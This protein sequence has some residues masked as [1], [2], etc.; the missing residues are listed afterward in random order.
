[1]V[2]LWNE[3]KSGLCRRPCLAQT[4]EKRKGSGKKKM[5]MGIAVDLD[6]TAKPIG[7]FCVSTELQLGD[8]DTHEPSVGQG[9]ARREAKRFVDMSFG[10]RTATK[11]ILGRYR[12]SHGLGLDFYPAPTPARIQQCLGSHGS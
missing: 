7:R 12:L 8:A 3:R 6:T 10:L 1:M 9:V 5:R 11:K 4:A 2:K